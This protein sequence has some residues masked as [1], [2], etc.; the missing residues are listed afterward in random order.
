MRKEANTTNPIQ[1]LRE[2]YRAGTLEIED[3]KNDPL[4]QFEIWFNEAL[5]AEVIEPNA[6][7]LATA[8]PNGV[9]SARIVLLKKYDARGFV[10]YTNYGSRKGQELLENPRAALVFCWLDLQR[11]IRIAGRV[12]KLSQ[13]ESLAYFQS[14]PKSSQIGA[15]VSNQS[16]RLAFSGLSIG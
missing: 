7:T 11:Q 8:T 15:W 4:Q 9:P 6:M 13:E 14:R 12:E 3:A 5:K 1:S 16:Q 10:F 2:D